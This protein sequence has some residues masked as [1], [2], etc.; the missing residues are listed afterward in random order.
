[1]EEAVH[2]KL[3]EMSVTPCVALSGYP[4]DDGEKLAQACASFRE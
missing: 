3:L 4:M 2:G 1:V